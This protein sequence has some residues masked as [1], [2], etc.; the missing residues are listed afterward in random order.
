MYKEKIEKYID[1]HKE[2]ITEDILKLVRIKSDKGIPEKGMPYGQE[3]AQ[4]LLAA[5]QRAADFGF[6]TVN[7]ENYVGTVDMN[8]LPPCLDILAHLDVVPAAD[9]WKVTQPYEPV[10]K[11]GKLYGR[12]AIDDKGPAICAL[13][14]MRAI[15]DLKIPLKKNV[16]L[17][18]GTD[19]E[20]GS[21]DLEYY[22]KKE[23]EAPMAFSPDADFPLINTEK[24][25]FRSTFQADFQE[26]K[27]TPYI[28]AIKS[29][30]KQNVIPD[31]ADA[32]IIGITKERIQ[33]LVMRTQKET[34][35]I[36]STEICDDR[37][38]IRAK[39][40]GGHAA[41]P[42]EGNNAITALL[43]LLSNLPCAPSKGFSCI[44]ELHKI[45]PHGDWDGKAAGI[46]QEDKISGKLT[47][48]LNILNYS[49]E[50][51]HAAFDSRVPICAN[52]KNM[53]Q[54]LMKRGAEA[55]L[56]LADDKM[57]PAHHVQEDSKLVQTLLRCYE[58][59]SGNPGSC[60][61][62]GGG[63]YVHNLKN[64]VA[65]GC[66][67]QGTNYHMHGADEYAIL[68][69]LYMSAKIFAQAIIELCG[70]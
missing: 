3:P 32:E 28:L 14:A 40:T 53:R 24:G 66:S 1:E 17:I 5:L 65:F 34:G 63:T 69:E 25:G 49:P 6:K 7:H 47:I 38:Y 61:A 11:D 70:V 48:S 54:V 67:T 51:L 33:D 15:K 57:Y 45:F 58:M 21:S 9:D 41:S 68:E 42:E 27:N 18:L 13:Y 30:I 4:A 52:D 60:K 37:I 19:E 31:T 56:Q 50:K 26:N 46:A 55:G 23:K 44:K 10:V 39:G 22:Y 20:C 12:G 29:G 62:I 36:F 43:Q 2:E 16:R 35:V 59:Y 64:G 8:D